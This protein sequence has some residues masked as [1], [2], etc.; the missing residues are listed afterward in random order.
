MAAH[1]LPP[2]AALPAA[3]EA[4]EAPL[5]SV[6][7]AAWLR[8]A[9]L[10]L[11]P[12]YGRAVRATERIPAGSVVLEERP[13]L[14]FIPTPEA[15][16]EAMKAR[17]R[18]RAARVACFVAL[19]DA[20][21]ASSTR[22]SARGC[23]T[24]VSA[25]GTLTARRAQTQAA[26]ALSCHVSVPARML[27]FCAAPEAVRDRILQLYDGGGPAQWPKQAPDSD[28]FPCAPRRSDACVSHRLSAVTSACSRRG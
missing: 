25:R 17:A 15:A 4:A 9:E 10:C 21:D 14:A 13:L 23:A 28:A 2:P 22:Q 11:H 5:T 6:G 16:A 27:A 7:L 24:R 1:N 20:R 12:T 8:K 18:E 19:R 3:A 26:A